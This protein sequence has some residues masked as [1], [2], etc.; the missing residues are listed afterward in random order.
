MTLS[1]VELAFVVGAIPSIGRSY[2]TYVIFYK[3]F[4]HF[5]H[6]FSYLFDGYLFD[7][8]STSFCIDELRY[9]KEL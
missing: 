4:F 2:I 5:Y 3:S 1:S 9:L 6:L 8:L 7:N